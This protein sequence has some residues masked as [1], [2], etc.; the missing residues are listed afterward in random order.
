[1]SGTPE[2][3]LAGVLDVAALAPVA[4]LASIDKV[5]LPSPHRLLTTPSAPA[6]SP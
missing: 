2:S 3:P 1:M 5:R 6:S 4:A